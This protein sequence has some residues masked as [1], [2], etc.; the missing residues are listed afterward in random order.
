[1]T[2]PWGA[3][4]VEIEMAAALSAA[5]HLQAL[6][7][8][9]A[10]SGDELLLTFQLRCPRGL[11]ATL[12]RLGHQCGRWRQQHVRRCRIEAEHQCTHNA[13]VAVKAA[14]AAIAR[15]RWPMGRNGTGWGFIM[16]S[17]EQSVGLGS[18]CAAGN[19][20]G[21]ASSRPA[22]SRLSMPRHVAVLQL[23]GRR[24]N[25]AEVHFARAA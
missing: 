7:F 23:R 5:G 15:S 14:S 16:G 10:P 21:F 17:L 18:C 9:C 25:L 22:M 6:L 3:V 24:L 13:V 4:G 19:F 12:R 2:S 8:R 11:Q 1:M 20:W